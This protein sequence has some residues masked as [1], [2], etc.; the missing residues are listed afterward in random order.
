M[1][2]LVT[3]SLIF[4]LATF[5]PYL[6]YVLL[7]F[8]IRPDPPSPNKPQSFPPVSI[9]L[10]TFNESSIIKKK[11]E[12]LFSLDYLKQNQTELDLSYVAD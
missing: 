2:A 7:F 5:L 3:L 6:F 8:L 10:P 9:I 1:D 12:D 11:L 4:L